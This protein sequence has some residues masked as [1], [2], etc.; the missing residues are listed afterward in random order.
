[1]KRSILALTVVAVAT[2][3]SAAETL[4]FEDNFDTLNFKTW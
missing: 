1:M 3:A 4:I 2:V